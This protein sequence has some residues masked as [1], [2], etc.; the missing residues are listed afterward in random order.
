[1]GA[2]QRMG[3]EA[4]AYFKELKKRMA[5]VPARMN[6]GTRVIKYSP[7]YPTQSGSMSTMPLGF[8]LGSLPTG[9]TAWFGRHPGLRFSLASS[10]GSANHARFHQHLSTCI[11]G[12][13]GPPRHAVAGA[14]PAGGGT[15]MLQPGYRH[16]LKVGLCNGHQ[17]CSYA[18][19]ARARASENCAY[20]PMELSRPATGQ[21]T[22]RWR[23][24]ERPD[25]GGLLVTIKERP[26]DHF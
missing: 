4:P 6:T 19:G 11:C 10:S 17:W 22:L 13:Y 7:L 8:S 21:R 1:M 24:F 3:W 5:T 25:L 23:C 9:G 16:V 12:V 18:G 14:E 15:Y 20:V 2:T 26:I